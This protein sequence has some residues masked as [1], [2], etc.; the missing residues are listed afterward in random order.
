MKRAQGSLAQRLAALQRATDLAEKVRHAAGGSHPELQNAIQL[1]R[2]ATTRAE[3]RVEL[4][5][6][7]TVVALAGATGSGK[8]SLLN[9]LA[10]AAVATVGARR[11]TTAQAQAVI[12]RGGEPTDPGELLDWL[13]VTHRAEVNHSRLASA[14][15][16]DLPDVDS[17][18]RDHHLRAEHLTQRADVLVWVLDPQ[19][20]ADAV[21]HQQYLRPMARHADVMLVVL[22]QVDTLAGADRRPVLADLTDRL[23]ADGLEKVTVLPTS[24][25]TGEGLEDLTT[26]ISAV[27]RDR[28]NVQRRLS[29]DLATAADTLAQVCPPVQAPGVSPGVRRALTE[30]LSTAVG[31]DRVA[32]AVASSFRMRAKARTGWPITRWLGRFRVD[33]LRRLHLGGGLGRHPAP[34]HPTDGHDGEVLTAPSMP[35]QDPAAQAA[36]GRALTQATSDVVGASEPPWRQ[37]LHAEVSQ[38]GPEVT[39]SG[40]EAIAGV[41]ARSPDRRAG[42]DPS[43]FALCSA[44]QWLLF[45]VLAVGLLWLAAILGLRYLGVGPIWTPQ[46]GPVPAQPP[47]PELPAVPWPVALLVAGA[48]AGVLVAV[49]TA[50]AA[51]VGAGRRRRRMHRRLTE[52]IGVVAGRDVLDPLAGRVGE[53]EEY[54]DAIRQVVGKH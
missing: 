13:G 49:G 34:G 35:E 48:A 30:Q 9:A 53:A 39:Q 16:I 20:Y 37:Y 43:W 4:S 6:E 54:A 33:P 32:D 5:A 40:Q 17:L 36:V 22:N 44:L 50:V 52:A 51:R 18:R 46:L 12:C 29:A 11:P 1:A 26:A 25:T 2:G 31:A 42:K 14:V 45:A 15:L 23:A 47:W 24:A 38:Q 19:K 27:A 41:L 21:V 28:K 10:G 3:Q 8:S 7:H